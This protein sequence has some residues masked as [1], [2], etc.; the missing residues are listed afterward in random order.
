MLQKILLVCGILAA[1]L[2]VG[3]DILAAMRWEGYSYTAQTVSELRAVG[4]P[5]RAFLAPIL[6][7]Y[8]L[9]EIAFGLGVWRAANQKR[10]LRIAG[11]LLIGLGALELSA[12]FFPMNIGEPV[13]SLTNT[14]HIIGTV[15]TVLFILLIIGFGSTAA[16]NWFRIYSYATIL[17]LIVAGAWA[18]L[19]GPRLA[20]N[21]PTPWL[22]VRE[23]INIYGYM[24]WMAALAA[25]LLR[26]QTTATAG[27]PP[28][29]IGSPRLTPR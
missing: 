12:P 28:A 17:V 11:G 21:L 6:L 15:V 13:S 8:T 18:G 29:S 3:S 1:L 22:G 2:Y 4:A 16:G 24:L 27:K 19:D 7:L 14:L 20:A 9:L 23:R 25:V 26:A 5:T 10:G